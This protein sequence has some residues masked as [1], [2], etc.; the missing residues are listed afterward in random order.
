LDCHNKCYQENKIYLGKKERKKRK[1]YLE[2]KRR[3][4]DR[5]NIKDKE[6]SN[7]REE[8]SNTIKDKIEKT[9]KKGRSQQEERKIETK[10][11]RDLYKKETGTY[12]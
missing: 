5:Y 8:N 2:D 10:S 7:V 3:Q 4:I 12:R 9:E 11:Q 6:T 1:K